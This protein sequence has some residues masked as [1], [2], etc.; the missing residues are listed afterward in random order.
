[1]HLW[2][3]KIPLRWDIAMQNMS[4]VGLKVCRRDQM[5]EPKT[6]KKSTNLL[7]ICPSD[8][9]VVGLQVCV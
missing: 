8:S 9:S 7:L 4:P 1:M 6:H 5:V 3:N 2:Q